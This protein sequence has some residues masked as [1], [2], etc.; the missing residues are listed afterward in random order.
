MPICNTPAKPD[1]ISKTDLIESMPDHM[2]KYVNDNTLQSINNILS[3]HENMEAFKENILSYGHVLK[4][5]K[6]KLNSYIDAVKYVS[7]KL[8]GFTNKVAYAKTFPVAYQRLIDMDKSPKVIA[9]YVAAYNK[10]KLVN[11]I[12]EQT[13]IPTYVLNAHM[14]QEA[15]NAQALLMV[16]AKSEKVRS[17]AA[18]S[19]LTHLKRPEVQKVELNL[20][21]QE[22]KSIQAL[23]ESTMQ[24]V[25]QQRE[26]IENKH[27]TAQD[28]ADS[29]IIE[30]EAIPDDSTN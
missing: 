27:M 1:I 19:I 23:R 3:S 28:V 18:N 4:E 7:Y 11:L 9:A 17:D 30:V 13:F 5:G 25:K 2:K 24:L 22:D 8:F 14:F 20:G 12:Y 26:M 10:G 29:R 21:L 6:F 15:L 16:S